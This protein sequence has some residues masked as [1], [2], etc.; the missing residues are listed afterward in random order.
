MILS[1][2]IGSSAAACAGLLA[3]R[4]GALTVGGAAAATAV[5]GLVFAA[6][7]LGWS[8]V[9]L[10]FFLTSSALSRLPGLPGVS[11]IAAKSDRR[12]AFQVL[13]NGGPAS[14]YALLALI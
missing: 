8:A 7:G 2:V 5:G 14:L 4:A 13:T 12:D 11:D 3:V 1:L 10:V 9:L 6:G